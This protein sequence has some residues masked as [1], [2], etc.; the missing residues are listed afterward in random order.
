MLDL[1]STVMYSVLMATTKT[2]NLVTPITTIPLSFGF[3][4][5]GD[6]KMVIYG[7]HLKL[8]QVGKSASPTPL[9]SPVQAVVLSPISLPPIH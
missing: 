7:H 1:G 8:G 9:W 6:N 4:S 3:E 2:S 5:T